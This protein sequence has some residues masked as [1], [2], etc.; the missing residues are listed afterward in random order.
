MYKCYF[1]HSGKSSFLLVDLA[2]VSRP[3]TRRRGTTMG[4]RFAVTEK[5]TPMGRKDSI[6]Y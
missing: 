3:F 2:G 1:Q 6:F 4:E 5:V